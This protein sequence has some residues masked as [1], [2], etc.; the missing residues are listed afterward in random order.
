MSDAVGTCSV[1]NRCCKYAKMRFVL[2]TVPSPTTT[3]FISFSRFG[4]CSFDFFTFSIHRSCKRR[5]KWTNTKINF[6]E[7]QTYISKKKTILFYI[8]WLFVADRESLLTF[9][10][11]KFFVLFYYFK[12]SVVMLALFI[13]FNKRKTLTCNFS[14]NVNFTL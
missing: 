1:V 12:K 8:K 13:L 5:H 3:H 4:H 6:V 10:S 2:P 7:W 11:N 14:Q 9:G